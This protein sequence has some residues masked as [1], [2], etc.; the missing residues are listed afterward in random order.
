MLHS[1][2]KVFA[3]FLLLGTFTVRAQNSDAPKMYGTLVS[4]VTS[5]RNTSAVL[6]GG[7]G[8]W[9]VDQRFAVGIEGYMLLS[10]VKAQVPDTSGNRFLTADYGGVDLEYS[11]PLGTRYSLTVQT[12]IGGGS[13]G[14]K[15]TPYLDR[16]QYHDPFVVL[17]PGASVEI[18]VTRIFRIGAGASYRHVAFLK[19]DL[20]TR[21]E[22]SGPAGFLSLKVGFF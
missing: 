16:R 4:K 13:I 22:L 6:V 10:N 20:A 8:G 12:L 11:V 21:Q 3:V 5:I 18:A 19:S 1:R 17:E 14:H 7:R 9:I 2:V 15:E